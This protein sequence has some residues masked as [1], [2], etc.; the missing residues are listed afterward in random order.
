MSDIGR[1]EAL[2]GAMH[3][4]RVVHLEAY[5]R[6]LRFIKEKGHLDEFV[7]REIARHSSQ[8]A[9]GD[10]AIRLGMED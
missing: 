10:A 5:Q 2:L 1:V 4:A 7:D 6:A 3:A 9:V 8:N